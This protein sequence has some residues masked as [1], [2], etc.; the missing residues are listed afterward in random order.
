M[1]TLALTSSMVYM[2]EKSCQFSVKLLG[3]KCEVLAIIN[4]N[5]TNS[6]K[7][8]IGDNLLI[9]AVKYGHFWAF[10]FSHIG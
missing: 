10:S 6:Q 3:Q 5:L 7:I 2:I 9:E 1:F 4:E 8:Q